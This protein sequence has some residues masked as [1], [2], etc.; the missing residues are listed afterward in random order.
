MVRS[1]I[2]RFTRQ[3]CLIVWS[4][5]A[6]ITLI[7]LP[8]KQYNSCT[9]ETSIVETPGGV[10][11][12][13][14]LKTR[15]LYIMRK[16]IYTVHSDD[17]DMTF[18]ME[19]T[20]ENGILVRT[21]VKGFYWGQPDDEATKEFYGETWSEQCLPVADSDSC[22]ED[23]DGDLFHM[24]PQCSSAI[25]QEE[26][27]GGYCLDCLDDG[28]SF[29][30]NKPFKCTGC[31]YH[32]IGS[33]FGECAECGRESLVV[34]TDEEFNARDDAK[35]TVEELICCDRC[36]DTSDPEEYEIYNY[37]VLEDDTEINFKT[38]KRLCEKC[39][40]EMCQEIYTSIYEP[41]D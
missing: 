27:D 13:K 10:C 7:T 38:P 14:K 35:P 25:T 11:N 22:D 12:I 31:G 8:T 30:S 21:E 36:Q 28:T 23:E 4:I 6:L 26:H 33:E 40:G 18:I 20:I 9:D 41:Q 32:Q 1:S 17:Y 29:P 19:D 34:I 24:C 3:N 39:V 15:R 16:K 5:G 37:L 2:K